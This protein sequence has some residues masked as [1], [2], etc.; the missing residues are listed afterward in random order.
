MRGRGYFCRS[1]NMSKCP[2]R[3]AGVCWEQWDRQLAHHPRCASKHFSVFQIRR[4]IG[5]APEKKHVLDVYF[6]GRCKIWRAINSPGIAASIG[7]MS[8]SHLTL[9]RPTA[10]DRKPTG[11]SCSLLFWEQIRKL[12]AAVEKQTCSVSVIRSQMVGLVFLH[13][14]NLR[15]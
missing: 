8:T 9:S 14:K 12:M 6:M 10:G 2:A 5:V 3:K 1:G 15:L 7:T 11:I 13:T 4:E